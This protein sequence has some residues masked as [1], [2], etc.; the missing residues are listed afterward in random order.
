MM[1]QSIAS[2]FA[3]VLTVPAD[4]RIMEV[5]FWTDETFKMTEQ[6]KIHIF[7]PPFAMMEL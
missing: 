1:A 7:I 6:A 2:A 5:R 3:L 4:S